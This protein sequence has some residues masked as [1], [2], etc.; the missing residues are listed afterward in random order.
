MGLSGA[1]RAQ[2]QVISISPTPTPT[3]EVQV[4][5]D[6][7]VTVFIPYLDSYVDPTIGDYVMLLEDQGDY[8]CLGSAMTATTGRWTFTPTWNSSSG[9]PP[10][11][12][13]GSIAGW[14]EMVSQSR[15]N[16]DIQ[17]VIGST[18]SG[19]SS[20]VY[21]FTGMPFVAAASRSQYVNLKIVV[22]AAVYTGHG[23]FV[24]SQATVSQ[25]F[26]Q[27]NA[28]GMAQFGFAAPVLGVGSVVSLWGTYEIA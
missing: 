2:G 6:P 28:A 1:R 3:V 4:A 20:G 23:T 27:T 15:C 19:G 21:N 9:T 24:A 12:G 7:S 11:I 25:M 18:T 17:L 8:L 5:A 10:S 26:Y 22:G 16:F 14:F 13:N